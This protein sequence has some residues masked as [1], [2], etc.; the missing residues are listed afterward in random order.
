MRPHW[1]TAP[2]KERT[3]IEK[4][5]AEYE[6]R[7][8]VQTASRFGYSFPPSDVPQTHT[9][10]RD[11][12]AAAKHT[13][14]LNLYNLE[15]GHQYA[16]ERDALAIATSHAASTW[17]DPHRVEEA[18]ASQAEKTRLEAREKFIATRAKELAAEDERA[19]VQRFV[20]QA[21]K[22]FDGEHPPRIPTSHAPVARKA[23]AS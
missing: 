8:A 7:S 16:M 10:K 14:A 15:H 23:K 6:L 17:P 3:Q 22:E 5:L 2:E 1:S 11:A 4:L 20:T 18:R 21:A 19:R 12:L 9:R 13:G